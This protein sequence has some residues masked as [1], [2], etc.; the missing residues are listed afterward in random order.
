MI[1]KLVKLVSIRCL[2]SQENRL[3]VTNTWHNHV[4][5]TFL[6]SVISAVVSL[7]SK[8]AIFCC[9]NSMTTVVR[10]L[11]RIVEE[12]P[13]EQ[14]SQLREK[15]ENMIGMHYLVKLAVAS[16]VLITLARVSSG[17]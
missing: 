11:Q 9:F 13:L 3:S 4:S 7:Q 15:L 1:V 14:V 6:V 10:K 16:T 8:Y 5:Q 12:Q 17:I 2:K